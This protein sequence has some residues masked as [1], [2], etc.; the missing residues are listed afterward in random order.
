MSK[1]PEFKLDSRLVG[2][3]AGASAAERK[4]FLESLPDLASACD[5]VE[6]EQPALAVREKEQPRPPLT[7]AGSPLPTPPP[8]LIT[9]NP[10]TLNPFGR[11]QPTSAFAQPAAIAPLE[12]HGSHGGHRGYYH[13]APTAQPGYAQPPQ[14]PLQNPFA[15]PSYAD[16]GYGSGHYSAGQVPVAPPYGYQPGQRPAYPQQYAAPPAQPPQRPLD[17]PFAPSPQTAPVAPQPF[18]QPQYAA[19]AQSRP[20]ENPFAPAGQVRPS[21]QQP[22]PA[23]P[24]ASPFAQPQAPVYGSGPSAPVA[25]RPLYERPAPESEDDEP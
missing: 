25:P 6:L 1:K 2:R 11:P 14:Q 13:P 15:P 5:N 4:A 7:A 17:N 18:Q 8:G 21:Y 24:V 23:A 10:T 22:A 19:P 20:L 12:A 9:P 16:S 3:K